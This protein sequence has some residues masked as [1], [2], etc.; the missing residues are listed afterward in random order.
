[1]AVVQEPDQPHQRPEYPD[2]RRATH[3]EHETSATHQRT[4]SL[5]PDGITP[6]LCK[7]KRVARGDVAELSLGPN[8]RLGKHYNVA[9]MSEMEQMHC[10]PECSDRLPE[11]PKSHLCRCACGLQDAAVGGPNGR[12]QEERRCRR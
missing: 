5:T 10:A 9:G 11:H 12:P 2:T 7:R 8:L 6:S 1:M 4:S 3:G